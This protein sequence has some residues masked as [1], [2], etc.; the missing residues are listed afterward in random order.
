MAAAAKVEGT[1]AAAEEGIAVTK[2]KTVASG[3]ERA[4]I[5]DE[6]ILGP[7]TRKKDDQEGRKRTHS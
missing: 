7:H 5:K 6:E 1:E 2:G 3:A 4:H